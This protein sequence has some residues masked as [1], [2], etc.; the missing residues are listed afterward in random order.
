M[1]KF[2][3]KMKKK[4]KPRA[5]SNTD[6]SPGSSI[7]APYEFKHNLHV[8]FDAISGDF[9]DLPEPWT[10]WLGVSNITKA[11]QTENPDAVLNA[12]KI[13]DKLD[14]SM[15]KKGTKYMV[16]Q[17]IC[18]NDDEDEYP[19]IAAAKPCDGDEAVGGS[20]NLPYADETVSET[21]DTNHN[22]DGVKDAIN[23][24]EKD[25]QHMKTQ[26]EPEEKFERRQRKSTK[27][28]MSEEEI[29][30]A[31]H[32]IC[33]PGDPMEVYK[34]GK[35]VGSGASGTV[36]MAT[37]LKTGEPVAIKMMDLKNQPKKE[38][39]ITEIQVMKEHNHPNVVNYVNSYLVDDEL[40]VVMEYLEG[41]ALTDVVT[42]T[43]MS[44]GLIAAVSKESLKALKFLH[45]RNIIHRDIKSDNVLLG[46]NGHVKLTD[47]GF[48]AQIASDASKRTT[49]VGTP[50][51]MAPEVVGR[52]HYDKKVDI[53]SLGIMV[54]EM[55]DGEPPYMNETPL[56]ALYLI[57]TH[58]KPKVKDPEKYSEELLTFIDRC[59]EV[60]IE[61]RAGA[62]ELLQHPFL[63]KASPLIKLKPLIEAAKEQV[64]NK[65]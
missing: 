58:G 2:I 22:N 59:L 35:K 30:S 37:N 26:D 45:D 10:K 11:E 62:A 1:S 39:I 9:I 29:M 33:D 24:L 13:F 36:H 61:K 6:S 65:D 60:S 64:H 57:A 15:K 18:S 56:K 49:M 8:G 5:N 32:A 63:L 31:L 42:E 19:H 55:M 12:L 23:D 27:K 51:W 20:T 14:K 47:F 53:W 16:N 48:C 41:G 40:W 34:V 7:G 46:M 38:L 3:E 25:V 28:K 54:M 52:K 17:T 43:V 21:S 4:K 50:Y 44:E